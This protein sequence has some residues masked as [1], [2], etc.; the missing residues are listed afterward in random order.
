MQAIYNR[1]NEIN[2]FVPTKY[3]VVESTS[4]NKHDE[5][6]DIKLKTKE[7]YKLE[8]LELAIEKSNVL[9]TNTLKVLDIKNKEEIKSDW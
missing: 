3:L 6:Y 4:I 7:K 5:E 2:N 9:N 8:D 1:D